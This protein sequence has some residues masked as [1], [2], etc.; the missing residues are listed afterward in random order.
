MR[1]TI[2]P[3]KQTASREYMRKWYAANKDRVNAQRRAA[4]INGD[5]EKLNE[6]NR[7]RWKRYKPRAKIVNK[8]W[9][10]KSREAIKARSK[11]WNE[12]NREKCRLDKV[13]KKFGLSADDYK[14]LVAKQNGVCAVCQRPEVARDGRSGRVKEL[15]VD[16]DHETGKVRG[17]LCSSCNRAI[18]HLNEDPKLLLA[19]ANYLISQKENDHA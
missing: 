4:R 13:Q 8:A 6:Q 2:D 14:A 12:L 15:A 11:K 9:R 18:G 10:E 19:A 17:L 16:H 7:E 1:K 3:E 5:R